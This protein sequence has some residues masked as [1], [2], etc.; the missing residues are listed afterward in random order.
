M[1]VA[2]LLGKGRLWKAGA[3]FIIPLSPSVNSTSLGRLWKASSISSVSP[4]Q[5]SWD[6]GAILGWD[7][8]ML[9]LGGGR[10]CWGR[11]GHVS[12][13]PVFQW[14][15]ARAV[16]YSALK[17]R[18]APESGRHK[19]IVSVPVQRCIWLLVSSGGGS[20]SCPSVHSSGIFRRWSDSLCTCWCWD[21]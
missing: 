9:W 17:F 6:S 16:A 8:D 4:P 5:D 2:R 21:S 3:Q 12:G 1:L 15:Y 10:R 11:K 14:F 13:R 19:P 18:V 7:W 20:Y